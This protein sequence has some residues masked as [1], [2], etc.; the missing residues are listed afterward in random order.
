MP[1]VDNELINAGTLE[2]M[3][4]RYALQTDVKVIASNF[5]VSQVTLRDS[6]L[7]DMSA[8]TVPVSELSVGAQA[9]NYN[10]APT[11]LVPVIV[12]HDNERI[13][14]AFSWGLVP[15]WAKDVSIG[16]R[17]INARVETVTEKPMFRQAI[18]QRRCLVPADGWFEWEVLANGKKQP[19][20]FSSAQHELLAFAGIYE[21]W[22]TPEGSLFWSVSVMT[23]DAWPSIEKIHHRMPIIVHPNLQEKWLGPGSAP[24]QEV[25]EESQTATTIDVWPVSVAVGNVRNNSPELLVEVPPIDSSL[26]N[27]TASQALS[28]QDTLF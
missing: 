27:Q 4:G 18:V 17:A 26:P 20:Y 23:M 14:S 12:R 9:A 28:S 1:H 10:V 8:T 15:D 25:V 19:Y 7:A 24:L 6:H 16:A 22:R 11:H 5:N 2:N 13:L 21:T 3:C